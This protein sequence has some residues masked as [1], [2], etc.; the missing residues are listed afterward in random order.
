MY[1][2]SSKNMIFSCVSSLNNR[3]YCGNLQPWC[4][5]GAFWLW[6]AMTESSTR[7]PGA[8]DAP[9]K[10]LTRHAAVK[11]RRSYLF[12]R[13]IAHLYMILLSFRKKYWTFILFVCLASSSWMVMVMVMSLWVRPLFRSHVWN[14]HLPVKKITTRWRRT[15]KR[16]S[17]QTCGTHK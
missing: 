7:R 15:W 2:D 17:Q 12:D 9:P 14:S 13:S 6:V 5:S 11:T 10:K 16:T 8:T 1:Y 4:E 3:V